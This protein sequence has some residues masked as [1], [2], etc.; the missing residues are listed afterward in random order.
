M[1]A[2]MSPIHQLYGKQIYILSNV[3]IKYKSK[4]LDTE[5]DYMHIL[6][7]PPAMLS[8]LNRRI[9]SKKKLHVNYNCMFISHSIKERVLFLVDWLAGI[10]RHALFHW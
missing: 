7:L 4:P 6:S 5:F 1:F 8:L 10:W 2:H 9:I 3:S